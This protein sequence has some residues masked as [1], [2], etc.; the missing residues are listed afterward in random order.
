MFIIFKATMKNIYTL[1]ILYFLLISSSVLKAQTFTVT[2]NEDNDDNETPYTLRE[3]IRMVNEAPFNNSKVINFNMTNDGIPIDYILI[4]SQLP[5][6][7]SNNVTINGINMNTLNKVNI[8]GGEWIQSIQLYSEDAIT[9]GDP[10]SPFDTFLNNNINNIVFDGFLLPLRFWGVTNF[11]VSD[12]AFYNTR[13]T[14]SGPNSMIECNNSKNGAIH[15]NLILAEYFG[16]RPPDVTNTKGIAAYNCSDFTINAN[17]IHQCDQGIEFFNTQDMLIINNITRYIDPNSEIFRDGNLYFCIV[18]N[19]SNITFGG[20]GNENKI[21]GLNDTQFFDV[22]ISCDG[23]SNIIVLENSF[24]CL[25]SPISNYSATITIDH[26]YNNSAGGTGIPGELVYV[27]QSGNFPYTNSEPVCNY[28]DNGYLYIGN[29]EIADDGTWCIYFPSG[30]LLSPDDNITAYSI[31]PPFGSSQGNTSDFI[32]GCYTAEN[33]CPNLNISI[34]LVSESC[35]QVC[36]QATILENGGPISS[37]EWIDYTWFPPGGGVETG[38]SEICVFTEGLLS[39]QVDYK[40]CTYQSEYNVVFPTLDIMTTVIDATCDNSNGTVTVQAVGGQSPFVYTVTGPLNQTSGSV[41]SSTYT[42]FN[43]PPGNYTASV[44][45]NNGCSAMQAITINSSP[46]PTSNI[47]SVNASCGE[48]NGSATVTAINGQSPYT[49]LWSTGGTTSTIN[50]L[51]VGTYYVTVTD[52]GNCVVIDSVDILS[53][54]GPVVS[55]TKTDATCGMATGSAQANVTGGTPPYSYSWSNGSSGPN[56]INLLPGQYSVT[57][58][59]SNNCTGTQTTTINSTGGP[60]VTIIKTDATCG[61]SNGSATASATGGTQ[62][63]MYLWSNGSTDATINNLPAGTYTVTVTDAENCIT[64]LSIEIN[65]MGGPAVIITKTDTNCGLSNGTATSSVTGGAQPYTYLWSNGSTTPMITNL[66]AGSYSLTVTDANNCVT[67]Q[68]TV[69]IEMGG[70]TVMISKTDANCGISNGTATSSVTGGTQPYTYLWSNGSTTP[71]ITNL[72]AGSY[73]LTVTDANICVTTQSTVINEMGGPA[74]MISKTDANCGESNGSATATA[75]GGTSPYSYLWSTGSTNSTINNLDVGT[76]TVTVTDA[77]NCS[78][79]NS[80]EINNIGSLTV[81]ITKTDAICGGANGS[82]NATPAG[83]TSPYSYLWSTGSTSPGI[84]NLAPGQYSVTVTDANNCSSIATTTINSDGG[85]TST[86]IS[87]STTCGL[88]NGSVVLTILTGLSPFDYN[89]TG[90]VSRSG[91]GIGD[92]SFQFNTLPPGTYTY[93]IEDNNGCTTNGQFIVNGSSSL[94]FNLVQSGFEC[95]QQ[96]GTITVTVLNG[97]GSYTYFLNNGDQNNTGIFTGLSPDNY[98]VSVI[99]S[100]GCEADST[101]GINISF[102]FN[103]VTDT[104]FMDFYSN[105]IIFDPLANDALNG[106]TGFTVTPVTSTVLNSDEQVIGTLTNKSATSSIFE[107]FYHG[108]Y[109]ALTDQYTLNYPFDQESM[110]YLLCSDQCPGVCD[111]GTIILISNYKCI[112]NNG[113]FANA[114][115]PNDDG[116][117]DV[118]VLPQF[119]KCNITGSEIGIY[120]RWGERVFNK[121]DYS[122]TW[123]G[124]NNSGTELPEGTYYYIL[125]INTS[126]GNKYVIKNFIELLR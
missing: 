73:S 54:N 6:I 115:T 20:S 57:V 100:K 93:I 4:F 2:S 39:L 99:D 22:G 17:E 41:F 106:T 8:I 50:N 86:S 56:I 58:T 114:F 91:N 37:P 107:Y 51:S 108:T 77:I 62:P 61:S 16:N 67:I 14:A 46:G 38:I 88:E 44:T 81:E 10:G 89:I 75:S 3:A 80:I 124:T 103:A 94:R 111:T 9:F 66:P 31:Q 121:I 79:V 82:A 64:T 32:S 1:L 125:Q 96:S 30:F 34:D 92:P 26:V 18:G 24:D 48:S 36:V 65:N 102:E 13:S 52:N 95:A 59:D 33:S 27:Y 43:F 117:N 70:P 112:D 97:T 29:T 87:E 78:S 120:N 98:L 40:C 113:G 126:D 116:K 55:I 74:V 45:D 47:V 60:S 53:T 84:T 69:I 7:Q 21:Y 123:D 12:C 101:L 25:S 5:Y 105:P 72:P 15:D 119:P 90:P 109:D 23:T 49:Y 104:V 110:T 85:P 68:S 76:Y 71:M 35:T 11:D 118:L 83:G 28:C 122:N 19:S 63:Y 42:F